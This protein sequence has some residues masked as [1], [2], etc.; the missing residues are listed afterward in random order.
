M[1]AGFATDTH[2]M[3]RQYHSSIIPEKE[4]HIGFGPVSVTKFSGFELVSITRYHV[5]FETGFNTV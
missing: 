1:E 4:N 5:E 2:I 3:I